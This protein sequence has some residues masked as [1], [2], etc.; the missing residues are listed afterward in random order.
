MAST[1]LVSK[2]HR[3]NHGKAFLLPFVTRGSNRIDLIVPRGGDQE[4]S[5]AFNDALTEETA[6]L[7]PE[8]VPTKT[9]SSAVVSPSIAVAKLAGVLSWI[10]KSY[11][12]RLESRPILTK[13]VTAGIIFGLSDYLAQRVEGRGSGDTGHVNDST[14]AS[15][16][17]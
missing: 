1:N 9:T 16:L 5:D 14:V 4:T 6:P 15:K 7:N 8:P 13:S 17:D 11:S 3:S 10:G 2:R 12:H